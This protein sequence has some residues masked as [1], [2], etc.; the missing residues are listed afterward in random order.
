MDINW[1]ILKLECKT[2]ENGLTNIVF[3]IHWT[4]KLSTI[5]NEQEY[6][7]SKSLVTELS[8]PD[9]NNFTLYESLTKE[10]VIG[11]IEREVGV[12]SMESLYNE[13][14]SNIN[15]QINPVVLVLNPPF[16]N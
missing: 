4:Y 8:S 5:V 6:S 16:E 15:Q 7:S 3:K 2:L 10:Q 11:W 1:N 14:E 13:L 12:T 9:P